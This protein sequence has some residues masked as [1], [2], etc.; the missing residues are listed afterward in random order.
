LRNS[1]EPAPTITPTA[2]A[3]PGPLTPRESTL[4]RLD[5]GVPTLAGADDSLVVREVLARYEGAYS[6][7]D[8]DA[9]SRVWPTVNRTALARA[10]DGLARQNVSLGNCDVTVSGP[11]ARATCLGTAS[12]TPK[13]G[14]G[15]RTAERRWNFELR[16]SGE[17][18]LI[19]RAS[20]R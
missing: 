16:K 2:P 10:F 19:Q 11:A 17:E 1:F 20:A 18:W 4:A 12:W 14:G 8:A 15:Q 5:R 7:L 6:S 9:A 13:V 3:A